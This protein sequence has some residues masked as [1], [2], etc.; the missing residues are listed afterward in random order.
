MGVPLCVGLGEASH[1]ALHE[2]ENEIKRLP[3]S[4]NISFAYVEGEGLMMGL[5][6]FAVSSGS[7][8]TSV[9][10][11]PSYVLKAIGVTEDLAHTSIRFCLG[12][13][14]TKEDINYVILRITEET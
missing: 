9:S 14:T 12:N 5:K 2:M 8:C 13:Y 3:G 6:E 1:I 10:L 11:E 4:L 7:A